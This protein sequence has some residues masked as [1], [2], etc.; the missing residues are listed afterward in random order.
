MNSIKAA[1]PRLRGLYAGTGPR[2]VIGVANALFV[3]LVLGLT[4]DAGREAVHDYRGARVIQA[5]NSLGNDLIRASAVTAMERG[6]TAA[7]LGDGPPLDPEI[8]KTM[9]EIRAEAERLGVMTLATARDLQGGNRLRLALEEAEQRHGELVA[10][11]AEVDRFLATGTRGIEIPAW[12]EHVARFNAS[13][14]KLRGAAFEDES[15]H[16][17]MAWLNLSLRHWIWLVSEYAGLERG[18]LAYYVSRREPIPEAVG[19]LLR[20]YRGVVEH[21]LDE[22][23]S[24]IH[25]P[26]MDPR[27]QTAEREMQARFYNRFNETRHAVYGAADTGAYPLSGHEW[28]QRATEAINSVLLLADVGAQISDEIAGE[29]RRQSLWHMLRHGIVALLAVGLAL[30]VIFKVR[31]AANQ[32]FRE[33]EMAEVTLHSIGDAVITTDADGMIEYLNPIAEQYTGWSSA[34]AEGR[35]LG[36]VLRFI[37]GYTR[38]TEEDPISEC[39]RLGR[40][41]ALKDNTVLRRRDGQEIAIEDSAAP[42]H[43]SEGRIVGAVMVFYDVTANSS[44]RHLLA[45]YASHDALTGLANRREFDRRL[46]GLLT[47]ARRRGEQHALCYIDLDQFKVVNDTCGHVVGDKL[48]CQ[49]TYLLQRHIRDTDTLARLGGDEFGLLLNNCPLERAER[50]AETI[51]NVIKQFHFSWEGNSFELACS[52]GLVPITADSI[53]PAEILSEADAACFTAKE[54]GRNRVQLFQP[55]DIELARRHGEMQWVSRLQLALKENRLELHVQDIVPLGRDCPRHREILLRLRD[56]YGGLVP[57]MSFIPAAERYNL[58]PEIDRWVIRGV[59]EWIQA[60]GG[61]D[62]EPVYNIN[63]SGAS[64][65]DCKG[66][67]DFIIGT[68]REYGVAPECVCFEIT[69]TAAVRNLVEATELIGEL[70]KIGFRFALDDFGSGLSSFMYLKALP[71][72]FLK[73]DGNF[74]RDM[75]DN[76]VDHAMVEA[77]NHIGHVMHLRTVA[78]FVENDEIINQLRSMG[79]DYGQG[80]GLDRPR[81]LHPGPV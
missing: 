30:L 11:R 68:F 4:L 16:N 73:I 58:M 7:A 57:P 70:K 79:V 12:I 65:S 71:V 42:I 37:N 46:T 20:S 9:L 13:L 5:A 17:E 47:R 78:E 41:I 1:L 66:L 19:D 55:G 32:L 40:I 76:A 23:R 80:Y 72:D 25:K 10:A 69:E 50:V 63:L 15:W 28:V 77:I 38:E 75:V 35:H 45:H 6:I 24:L 61:Q 53:S 14:E 8:K 44:T 26:G 39:L 74:V 62:R 36:D 34:E 52:I 49:L 54:K 56:E 64:V 21:N 33:K 48:L 3:L 51:R 67:R 31:Q 43:D 22:V 29:I 18:V 2:K 60:S 59:C 27:L 81:P